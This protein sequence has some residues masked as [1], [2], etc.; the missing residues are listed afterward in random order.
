[1]RNV[2]ASIFSR[3][4][5]SV[6]LVLGNIAEAQVSRA[7]GLKDNQSIVYHGRLVRPDKSLPEGSLSAVFKIYSP[8]P[9]LCLLWAETQTVEFHN[10]SFAV[11]LGHSTNRVVGAFGGVAADFNQAFLNNPS[12]TL[13]SASCAKG[14]AYT[15]AASDDRLL[16][17]DFN[18][19]GKVI[20]IA[21][22]PIKSVPY[23]LQAAEIAG[24]GIGNL[25][26]ISGDSNVSF[27]PSETETLKDLLGGDVFFDLKGRSVKNVADPVDPQDA[28]TKAWVQAHVSSATATFGT[29]A[30]V[31]VS[32]GALGVTN[33]TT[34]PTVSLPKA[35]ALTSGY[36]SA[37]DWSTFNGKQPAG[38]YQTTGLPQNQVWVGNVSGVAAPVYLGIAHLRTSLGAAQFPSA[39][40]ASQT[41]TWSAITDALSCTNIAISSAAVSGLGALA[42]KN[43]ADLASA[44]VTGTLP[45][46]RGG[47][48][49]AA[50]LS[51]N[52]VMVSAGGA[53]VENAAL[54][55]SRV[56]ITG[57]GGLPAVSG[58][59]DAE[60]GY[61]GGV[62]SGVQTQLGG[63]VS[64]TGDTM[65]GTL[66]LAANGLAVGTSQLVVSGG[67]VGIG[68]AGPGQKLT[69]AGTIHST[70]GGIKFPDGTTQ[71]TAASAASVLSGTLC[72]LAVIN[73]YGGGYGCGYGFATGSGISVVACNGV[74][75][76][77]NCPAGYTI[78][79]FGT[80][81]SD[82][83]RTCSKN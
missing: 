59:T 63:K 56:V 65:T 57:A 26:K 64:K 25:M 76:R 61:L 30:R 9:T 34:T 67:N 51:N 37:A 14:S 3:S 68:T 42:A 74:D 33:A 17:A 62:T 50:T 12:M 40:S 16:S 77:T 19:A 24:F 20:E 23:A 35:D 2:A 36:L 10:G 7:A 53:I 55:P 79:D 27:T 31:S 73:S 78:V 38:S 4:I 52:R 45:V 18:D 54:T 83:F 21:G 11:E 29:V 6:L 39:C 81:T 60:L 46:A 48:N 5:I 41:L 32:G 72:G 75:L 44:D 13:T 69:V 58:V 22:L 66:N 28:A 43:T 15:P 70:S 71:T 82:C 47:T 8:E 1:M 49:S 80:S